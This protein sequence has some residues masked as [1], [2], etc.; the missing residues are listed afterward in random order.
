MFGKDNKV[1]FIDFGFAIS[2]NSANLDICGT[3]Y[4]IAPEVLA[5]K[6]GKECDMWSLGVV[7]YQILTGQ[8][9]FDSNT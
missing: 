2:F 7:L 1:K 6:Y 4:Y 8:Y 9:P 5:A 3:P